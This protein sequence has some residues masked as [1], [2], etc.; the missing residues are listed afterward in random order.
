MHLSRRKAVVLLTMALVA[1]HEGTA[2]KT[3]SAGFRLNDINGRLLPTYQAPTPGITVTVLGGS[4]TLEP[5]GLATMI[6]ERE[7]PDGTPFVLAGSYT[8]QINGND[9]SFTR[10]RPCPIEFDCLPTPHGT[11]SPVTGALAL[12]VGQ[13]GTTPIIYNFAP[14]LLD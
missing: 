5:T 2:P 10:S 6:E 4:L 8:Y 11:I 1:C 7:Q 13:F 3:I 9:V 12:Q 14:L